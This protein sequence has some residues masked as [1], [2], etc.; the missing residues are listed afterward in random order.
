VNDLVASLDPQKKLEPTNLPVE[1]VIDV[2]PITRMAAQ[3]PNVQP[4]E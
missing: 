2:R 1:Y 3:V 4:G